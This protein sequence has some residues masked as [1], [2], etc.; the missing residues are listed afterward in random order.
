VNRTYP[1]RKPPKEQRIEART[2]FGGIAIFIFD[3]PN[4]ML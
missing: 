2:Y 4:I 3:S 1:K